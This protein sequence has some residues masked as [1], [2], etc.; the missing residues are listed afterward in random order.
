MNCKKDVVIL[1]QQ[2]ACV[3]DDVPVQRY[4]QLLTYGQPKK[5]KLRLDVPVVSQMQAIEDQSQQ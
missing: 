5:K 3:K 4:D 1:P 2:K